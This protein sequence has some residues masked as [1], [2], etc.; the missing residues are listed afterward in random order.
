MLFKKWYLETHLDLKKSYS[1]ILDNLES[2]FFKIFTS[3]PKT[4]VHVDYH[5]KN[6]MLE[7]ENYQAP[8]QKLGILDF[9]DAMIGPITYDAS[10]LLQDA[11]VVLPRELREK[12]FL[13]HCDYLISK[14]PNIFATKDQL[15]EYF[16]LTGLQRH[17]KNL[18]IFARLKYFYGKPNYINF[19]PNLL[20]YISLVCDLFQDPSI[21][22]LK[23][24][25]EPQLLKVES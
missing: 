10:S 18:G 12:I 15:L 25:L 3:Q 11:Y 2:Y 1:K 22:M 5:S 17:I 16:Y 23:D 7:P 9:Q 21:K 13:T 8:N 24:L 6:I 4:F 14:N 20:H 19:I